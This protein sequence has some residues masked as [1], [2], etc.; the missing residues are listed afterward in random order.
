MT[1][2]EFIDSL[3][4]AL[5]G[6]LG[7]G[8]V[9][10]NVRY[11]QDYIDTKVRS[12]YSEEDAV[13]QLGDPRL[14]AR[15]IIE[16]AKQEQSDYVNSPEY[17]EVYEDGSKAENNRGTGDAKVYRMPGWLIALLVILVIIA[18]IALVGSLV[19][20]LLPFVIPVVFVVCIIRFFQ[21]QGKN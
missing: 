17:D 13:A 19:T 5:A 1:R 14:I 20:A 16:A 12:G 18:A 15:S 3:Q 2:T 8:Y 7:S 6:S 10:E 4:K 21:N 9:N 11:Y